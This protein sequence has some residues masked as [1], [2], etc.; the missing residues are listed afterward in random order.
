MKKESEDLNFI[1]N[2]IPDRINIS[3]YIKDARDVIK[4]FEGKKK[5]DAMFLD[6]FSSF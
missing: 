5:Y 6:P 4:E 3:I 1:K 2:E